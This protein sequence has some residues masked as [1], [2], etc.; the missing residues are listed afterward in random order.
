MSYPVISDSITTFKT[1]KYGA[2]SLEYADQGYEMAKPVV[3]YLSKP[4]GYVAPYLVRA[5]SLGDQGLTKIDTAFPIVKEY[6]YKIR[7]RIYQ[8]VHLP[9]RLAGDIKRHL[10]D[11]YGSE[12][13]QCGGDGLVARGKA[14]ITTSLA[15]SQESLA[16]V[17]SFLQT[18]KKQAKEAADER[19]N[20]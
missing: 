6:T 17:N 11:T 12:Y 9:M 18:K 15:L 1:N 4:F 14:M 2:K 16:W 10:F 19:A 13:K 20:S 8:N 5:D 7:G 3:P